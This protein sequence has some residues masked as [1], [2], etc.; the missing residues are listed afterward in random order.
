MPLSTTVA[1]FYA[2]CFYF[3]SKSTYIDA[4]QSNGFYGAGIIMLQIQQSITVFENLRLLAFRLL[5]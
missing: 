5:F 3:R 4:L 2:R 1:L